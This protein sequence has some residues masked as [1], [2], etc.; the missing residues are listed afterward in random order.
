MC[1]SDLAPGVELLGHRDDALRWLQAA[2]LVAMPSRWEGLPF[3]LLEAMASGRGV[4]A[5][6]IPPIREVLD[7]VGVLVPI[8]DAPALAHAIVERLLDPTATAQDANR[9]RDRVVAAYD[10]RV[11]VAAVLERCEALARG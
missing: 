2:D 4:V 11:Q 10:L 5:S 6:D 1:S 3:V 8:G 9:A 7:G